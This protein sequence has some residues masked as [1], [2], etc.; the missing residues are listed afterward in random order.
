M[1]RQESE[2]ERQYRRAE[3]AKPCSENNGAKHRGCDGLGMEKARDE[4][5]RNYRH[6]YRQ[7]RHCMVKDRGRRLCRSLKEIRST[8]SQCSFRLNAV[9]LP[10]RA[11]R[12]LNRLEHSE[13]LLQI[14]LS[15]R[16][17]AVPDDPMS[18][19]GNRMPSDKR[20]YAP[21]L[22]GLSIAAGR[23]LTV[24]L[25]RLGADKHV[26]HDADARTNQPTFSLIQLNLCLGGSKIG[27]A[28]SSN[29]QPSSSFK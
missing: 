10:I 29:K 9:K 12:S 5:G 8:H 1:E 25:T 7:Y 2:R 28:A 21:A 24:G 15:Q 22:N 16:A 23:Y 6:R 3:T 18:I 20:K 27:R 4:F 17:L 19:G 14:E 11:S 26:E 13:Q